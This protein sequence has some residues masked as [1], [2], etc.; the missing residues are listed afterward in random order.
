[1]IARTSIK[2]QKLNFK[3][4]LIQNSINYDDKFKK[5][6]ILVTIPDPKTR[7]IKQ[8]KNRPAFFIKTKMSRFQI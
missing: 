1:M 8:G 3:Y 7:A 6:D 5:D 4:N 2:K